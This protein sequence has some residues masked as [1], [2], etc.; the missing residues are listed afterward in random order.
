MKNSPT[1]HKARCRA[2]VANKVRP[3]Q[4]DAYRV[5]CRDS[6]GAYSVRVC[7]SFTESRKDGHPCCSH[8][9]RYVAEFADGP[10]IRKVGRKAPKVDSPSWRKRRRDWYAH[11]PI[12]C[13]VTIK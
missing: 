3:T 2:I 7:G 4:L 12:F 1:G 5:Y 11:Q 6:F 9:Q 10:V 13:E 8:H